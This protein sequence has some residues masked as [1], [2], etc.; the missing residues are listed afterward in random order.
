MVISSGLRCHMF[1]QVKWEKLEMI[2]QLFMPDSVGSNRDEANEPFYDMAAYFDPE[3][4]TVCL[5]EKLPPARAKHIFDKTSRSL[6][7]KTN[8]AKCFVWITYNSTHMSLVYLPFCYYHRL[9]KKRKD[10]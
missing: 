4:S 10:S 2:F 6:L 1:R 3:K 9:L 7:K 5:L 8:K